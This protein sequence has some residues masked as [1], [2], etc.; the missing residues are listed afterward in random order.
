MK[1][2]LSKLQFDFHHKPLLI[3]GK[4]MEYYGI[5]KAG[6]DI[7]FVVAAEDHKRLAIQY[8][9]HIKELYGDVG[10]IEYEFE[11]WNTICT[12]DYEY[13][14]AGAAEEGDYLVVSIEKL[15]FL[16]AIAMKADEKYRR[17]VELIADYILDT[18]Y[19]NRSAEV[20]R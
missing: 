19:G 14:K 20:G 4:A 18:A 1:I 11:T 17:D 15:L 13:L 6:K 3:G 7:D 10:I 16:K 9:E 12:F 5:R 2:D 8:P